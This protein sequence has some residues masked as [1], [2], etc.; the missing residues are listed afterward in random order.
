MVGDLCSRHPVRSACLN[1]ALRVFLTLFW[2]GDPWRVV[3]FAL[4]NNAAPG[5]MLGVVFLQVFLEEEFELSPTFV[6]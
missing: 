1:G 3:G 5:A 2:D 4:N 6:W